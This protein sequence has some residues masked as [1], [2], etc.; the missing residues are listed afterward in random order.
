MD[1]DAGRAAGER[2]RELTGQLL[3]VARRQV[4][5]PVALSRAFLPLLRV[6]PLLGRGLSDADARAG[7]MISFNDI[8]IL[9]VT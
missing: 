9:F 8:S 7:A 1:G 4:V 5:A 2:A 3:A 6:L